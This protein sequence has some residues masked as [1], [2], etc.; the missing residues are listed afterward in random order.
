MA[1][2]AIEEDDMP[3]EASNYPNDQKLV[4]VIEKA[5]ASEAFTKRLA[6]AIDHA[7]EKRDVERRC[8]PKKHACT[9]CY[10][11]RNRCR[12]MVSV[13]MVPIPFLNPFWWADSCH[14]HT[15]GPSIPQ[16]YQEGS[17]PAPESQTIK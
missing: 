12:P 9:R 11:P 5:L 17:D 6:E 7:L 3:E 1:V 13:M 4:E 14:P 10:P 2:G 16:C 15:C 8:Y